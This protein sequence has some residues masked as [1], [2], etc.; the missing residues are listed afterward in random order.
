M[1]V[2]KCFQIAA[3]YKYAAV[4]YGGECFYGNTLGAAAQPGATGCDMNCAGKNGE[5]CGGSYRMNLYQD[6]SYRP[7]PTYNPGVGSFVLRGCFSDSVSDRAL[8][9]SWIAYGVMTVAKCIE[10]ARAGKYRYAAV[11]FYGECYFGN[12][13]ALSSQS[14]NQCGV[15]C[16]GQETEICGGADAITLYEDTNYTPDIGG[17][18]LVNCYTDDTS[19]RALPFTYVDWS[20]MTIEKCKQLGVGYKYIGVEY[21]GEC[22]WGNEIASTSQPVTSGCDT[23]CTGNN[24]QICGGAGF[25]SIYA[26]GDYSEPIPP[27]V[28]PGDGVFE[29]SGCYTDDPDNRA[30]AFAYHDDQMSVALCFEKAKSYRYAAVQD[31]GVCYYGDILDTASVQVNMNECPTACS[32]KATEL[33]GGSSRSI[34]YEDHSFVVPDLVGLLAL[35]QSS[36][37]CEVAANQAAELWLSSIFAFGGIGAGLKRKRATDILNPQLAIPLE[38]FQEKCPP[39]IDLQKSF[40]RKFKV[41]PR[42]A[43]QILEDAPDPEVAVAELVIE[44][45]VTR[46]G[47]AAEMAVTAEVAASVS[48][49]S[50]V[51]AAGATAL[52]GIAGIIAWIAAQ[53]A[54]PPGGPGEEPPE[55]PSRTSTRT[56]TSSTCSPTATPTSYIILTKESTTDSQFEQM[57]NSLPKR[58]D[59]FEIVSTEASIRIYVA[60]M[61]ECEYKQLWKNPIVEGVSYNDKIKW[62]L[63]NESMAGATTKR[64]RRDRK[65][66]PKKQ[67]IQK[68]ALNK[69]TIN[70]QEDSPPHL[71]WL[72]SYARRTVLRGRLLG[73]EDFIFPENAGDG[74]DVYVIDSGIFPDHNDFTS[75]DTGVRKVNTCYNAI[76]G[77]GGALSNCPDTDSHGTA[78][79]SLINGEWSGVAKHSNVIPV[80]ILENRRDDI[81]ADR[82]IRALTWIADQVA[83]R[84]QEGKSIINLSGGYEPPDVQ[85]T[86]PTNTRQQIDVFTLFLDR[87]GG[88]QL[89]IITVLAAGNDAE[90]GLAIEIRTPQ[91]HGGSATNLI[92]VGNA[93]AD[94]TRNPKSSISTRDL[95]SFYNIGTDTLVAH[96]VE[97]FDWWSMSGTSNAAALT[98]GLIATFL[99]DDDIR[100]G[101]L[102]GFGTRMGY[103]A[104]VFL[105]A[106]AQGNKGLKIDNIWVASS[107]YWVPCTDITIWPNAVAP[108]APPPY[109]PSAGNYFP[110]SKVIAT[111]TT[112]A[113]PA[114]STV[115]CYT[116]A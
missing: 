55:G 66:E 33:C 44:E 42:Y 104:K 77:N 87:L 84:H 85:T 79:A 9:H 80:K 97:D 2:S 82:V 88:A 86:H 76:T 40:Q 7:P 52:V 68:R 26:N 20:A 73:Y 25:I 49:A 96:H 38:A 35:A 115:T 22:Y 39:C 89:K 58:A 31:G 105:H 43:I 109:Q 102:S 113:V 65:E 21:Y 56:S 100:T 53:L 67:R 19:H 72:S 13:L 11:E 99:S 6:Q 41:A 3:G 107:N 110:V 57:K 116:R 37:Q 90:D 78:M 29:L 71:Q 95:L 61:N 106:W 48:I 27:T 103:G 10:K 98:S 5:A 36:Q 34:L 81:D 15:R 32:G 54:R 46:L 17:F 75:M 47:A 1:T 69:A 30:L 23:P 59:N 24:A 94:N 74:I 70:L 64:V 111:S 28:N 83:R 18:T 93:R 8:Q 16:N 112:V 45:V 108:I 101:L 62:D 14:S 63:G 91:L 50:E 51:V 4:Q 12:V 60:T 92:I 114:E